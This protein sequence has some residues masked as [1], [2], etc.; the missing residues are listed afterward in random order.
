MDLSLC[1]DGAS[2][3]FFDDV[4]LHHQHPCHLFWVAVGSSA[5]C[6][7]PVCSDQTYPALSTTTPPPHSTLALFS[8]LSFLLCQPKNDIRAKTQLLLNGISVQQQQQTK[9][10]M[11]ETSM[12]G[13]RPP[14]N[15]SYTAS[16]RWPEVLNL[17]PPLTHTLP[18]LFT[19]HSKPFTIH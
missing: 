10:L 6:C 8:F 7:S 14:S 11:N 12:L 9:G 16:K 3:F 15:S 5:A 2:S 18:W 13:P 4:I 17:C 1:C 19:W